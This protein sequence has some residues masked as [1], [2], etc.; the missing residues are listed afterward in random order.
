MSWLKTKK[1]HPFE[2]SFLFF[3]TNH[4]SIRLLLVTKSD[5]Q[6]SSWTE[7]TLQSTVQSQ[8]CTQQWSRPLFGG[9][10]PVWSTTAFWISMRP[11]YL[12]NMLSKSL[13][14]TSAA[15]I[16]QQKGPKSSPQQCLT[17]HHTTNASKLKELD[18]KILPHPPYSPDLLSRYLDNFAVKMFPLPAGGRKCF[19]RVHRIPK[20][21]SLCYR[22]KQT[23][24]SWA[25]MCWL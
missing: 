10:L 9:L 15:G 19:P 23:Y 22:N 13:K 3:C 21:R 1:S 7:K 25:K 17:T 4:F 5:D 8:T 16:G 6:L 20:H 2:V 11:L 14:T 24:F 18:Y 12:R